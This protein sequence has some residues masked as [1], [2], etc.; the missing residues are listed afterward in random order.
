VTPSF[1]QGTYLERT[2]QSV[3]NQRYPNLEYLVID[4]GSSDGS[5]EIIQRY[6]HE[7]AFWESQPDH[8]VGH[9][10]NK[11]FTRTT[12]EIMGWLNADDVLLP[13]ALWSVGQIFS[14][15]PTIAWVTSG[16]INVSRDD[17]LF[18]IQTSRKWFSRWTQIFRYSPPPQ[19]CTFWRR[20][21]WERAGGYVVENSR[22]MDCELWLRFYEHEPL[23]IANTIFA[24]WRL[25]PTSFSTQHIK[26]LHQNLDATHRQYLE[27][28]RRRHLWVAL[29]LPFLAGYF[30][31]LDWDIMN[32]V[33]FELWRRRTRLLTFDLRTGC[34]RLGREKGWLPRPWTF[35]M[36]PLGEQ[37]VQKMANSTS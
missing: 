5:Q 34:F 6:A 18:T 16:S 10:L 28:Y 31:F 27:Q 14:D 36:E 25:H 24:A 12:G 35:A 21:L 3:L 11:G 13:N 33:W 17:R 22:Y 1:N 26:V 2:I 32:R 29:W 8:G 9:A 7:L 20:A 19:H 23:Y 30:R 15:Y 4:G 37:A